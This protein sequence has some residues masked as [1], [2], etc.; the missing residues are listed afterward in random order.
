[1]L[2]VWVC[3]FV[4]LQNHQ[5]PLPWLVARSRFWISTTITTII[6]MIIVVIIITQVGEPS[7]I[8]D[9]PGVLGHL[10][11]EVPCKLNQL[12]MLLYNGLNF[13]R[14]RLLQVLGCKNRKERD[15]NEEDSLLV[16]PQEK[17]SP[18]HL[19]YGPPDDHEQSHQDHRHHGKW[20]ESMGAPA[21][22]PAWHEYPIWTSL[23]EAMQR[24]RGNEWE[25]RT[26]TARVREVMR[27]VS[28]NSS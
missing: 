18:W 12:L 4:Y 25:G 17:G 21:V 27:W 3:L 5:T 14:K 9:L 20:G 19:F 6:I 1:M 13:W 16:Y 11:L 28:L 24:K 10:Q 2:C 15:K 22:G 23:W 8:V 26:H 7:R